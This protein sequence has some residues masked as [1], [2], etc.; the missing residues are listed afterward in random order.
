MTYLPLP[1]HCLLHCPFPPPQ[2][3]PPHCLL[4]FHIP[5]FHPLNHS[6]PQKHV[7]FVGSSSFFSNHLPQV[8]FFC[9]VSD[10]FPLGHVLSKLG[11][12]I[13]FKYIN[14]CGYI[15]IIYIYNVFSREN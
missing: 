7:F 4:P 15:F 11:I 10:H 12:I 8:H 6:H 14:C 3:L 9:Q 13:L 1:A 5:H 2:K